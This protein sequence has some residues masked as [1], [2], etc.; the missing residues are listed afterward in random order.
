MKKIMP[1][2]L[3]PAAAL[4]LV[5]L[6]SFTRDAADESPPGARVTDF[7]VQDVCVDKAGNVLPDDPARCANRRD[8]RADEAPP[9]L[10]TDAD[11]T[12]DGKR[13]QAIFSQPVRVANGAAQRV[14]V[15]K[16]MTNEARPEL[17]ARF[18]PGFD[19]TRDGYDLIEVEGDFV[20]IIETSDPGCWKQTVSGA[21]Q[22]DGWILFPTTLPLRPGNVRHAMRFE[23]AAK[24][25]PPACVQQNTIGGRYLPVSTVTDRSINATWTAPE[26]F[27]FESGKSLLAIKSE[28]HAHYDLS[29]TDNAIETFYFTREYGFS[30]WEA[31]VPQARCLSEHGPDAP[32]CHPDAP[33]NILRGRCSADTGTEQR[34]GQTWVRIDCRDTTFVLPRR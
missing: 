20:S 19:R 23:R 32:V 13:Y 31:W 34:G 5:A 24:N 33:D 6:L 25:P 15:S 9:Y 28:H 8:L 21:G 18:E 10:M 11:R 26:V 30:R 3:L 4:V 14:L 1:F 17:N 16:Q 22:G 27:A 2:V 12:H 29:R 7:L